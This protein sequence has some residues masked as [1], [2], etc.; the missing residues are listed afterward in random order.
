MH[1]RSVFYV[2][3]RA[4]GMV[5]NTRTGGSAEK[6]QGRGYA[7]SVESGFQPGTS[8]CEILDTGWVCVKENQS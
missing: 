2:C 7:E 5:Q 6:L 3:M 4:P 8:I 1:L